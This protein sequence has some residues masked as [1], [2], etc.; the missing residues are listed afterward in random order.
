MLLLSLPI[1]PTSTTVIFNYNLV[2]LDDLSKLSTF[3]ALLNDNPSRS[4]RPQTTQHFFLSTSCGTYL[5][6]LPSTAYWRN[7]AKESSQRSF[8]SLTNT[9]CLPGETFKLNLQVHIKKM[10]EAR[11]RYDTTQNSSLPLYLGCR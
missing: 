10:V 4:P 8:L 3:A 11:P 6:G 2:T 1:H 9:A 7:L 5:M